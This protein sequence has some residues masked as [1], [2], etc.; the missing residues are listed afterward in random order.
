MIFSLDDIYYI[1]QAMDSWLTENA[2]DC[3]DDDKDVKIIEERCTT[4]D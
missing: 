3:C 2:E 4:D 1:N